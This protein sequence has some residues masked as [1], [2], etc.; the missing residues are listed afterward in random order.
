MRFKFAGLLVAELKLFSPGLP[1]PPVF[2]IYINLFTHEILKIT[3]E[4]KSYRS[5]RGNHMLLMNILSNKIHIN[6]LSVMLM[7]MFSMALK[8]H[9]L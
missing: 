1:F 2:V 6:G 8:I 9:E 7:P 5:L 4:I 3:F